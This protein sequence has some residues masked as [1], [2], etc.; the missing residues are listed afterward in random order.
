MV[1]FA[2]I[3]PEAMNTIAIIGAGQL[4]SRHLQGAHKSR[5]TLDIHVVDS[6]K[7]SL[8]TA[9]S[10]YDQIEPG[11]YH[12]VHF[13]D[14]IA[15][16]PDHIDIA[17]VATSSLPRFDVMKEVISRKK[18]DTLIL[19]K[20]LFPKLW[21]YAKASEI[22]KESGVRAFVNCPRRMYPAYDIIEHSLDRT[23]PVTMVKKAPD[24]GL[25]CN[26]IHYID[27]FMRMTGQHKFE[28]DTRGLLPETAASKR[29]GYIE[30]YGTLRISTPRGD[31]LEMTSTE[32]ETENIL[33]IDN[34]SQNVE[35][36]ETGGK[37]RINGTEHSTPVIY[38]SDLSGKVV[39]MILDG[40][41]PELTPY[42]ESRVYHE[43]LFEA[44]AG[45][46][47]RLPDSPACVK[48]NDPLLPI[49]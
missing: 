37:T 13:S 11:G 24:W 41:T 22:I 19:E 40:I 47:R 42:E 17:I 16:L 45:F 32:W 49:T 1:N 44:L 23:L 9:R 4:G 12:S 6:C 18:I 20:F 3:N 35:I 28:V 46:V 33:T 48:T 10:R 15:D 2:Y 14:T 8:E 5:H 26:A 39:D 34:G 36:N 43:R 38:Q 30:L 29:A 27:I 25:C 7:K 21:Q 31:L